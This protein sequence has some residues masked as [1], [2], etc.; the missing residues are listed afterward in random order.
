MKSKHGILSMSDVVWN[1]TAHNSEWLNQHPDAAYS[2]ANS[3]HLQP[4]R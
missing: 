4:R 1:H 2:P 3:P